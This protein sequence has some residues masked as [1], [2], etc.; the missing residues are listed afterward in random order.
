MSSSTATFRVHVALKVG[1]SSS[2]MSN[3]AD[4]AVVL[5]DFPMGLESKTW[6]C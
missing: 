2:P 1:P 3:K 4:I 5:T 6:G